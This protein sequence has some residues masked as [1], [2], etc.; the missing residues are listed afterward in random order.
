MQCTEDS[1]KID[2]IK[3]YIAIR[4]IKKTNKLASILLN[5]KKVHYT[6]LLDVKKRSSNVI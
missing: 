2:D 6:S 1:W 4:T 5:A 3:Q